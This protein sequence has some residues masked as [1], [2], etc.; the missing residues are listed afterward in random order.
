MSEQSPTTDDTAVG[1]VVDEALTYAFRLELDRQGRWP[2]PRAMAE[3][4]PHDDNPMV[5]LAL[6]YAGLA[7][8]AGQD[9]ETVL[10][11]T[12]TNMYL[13]GFVAGY[14]RAAASAH[15]RAGEQDPR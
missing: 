1:A 12:A 9:L 2:D 14:D 6:T 4:R 8:D 7:L 11:A 10:R 5:A 13:E 3:A 15:G